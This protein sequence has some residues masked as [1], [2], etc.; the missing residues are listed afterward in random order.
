MARKKAPPEHA[1]HERW[2]VSYADFITLL[3]AFFVVM[4]ANSQSDAEKSERMAKA[5]EE[6]FGSPGGSALF[7]KIPESGIPGLGNV[8]ITAPGGKRR[9]NP[10]IDPIDH[11][12]NPGDH[13]PE[14]PPIGVDELY[15]EIDEILTKKIHEAMKKQGEIKEPPFEIEKTFLGIRINLGSSNYFQSGSATMKT[16]AIRTVNDLGREIRKLK[17]DSIRIRIE[18]HTDN[19]PLRGNNKYYDNEELSAVRAKSVLT[20]FLAIPNFPRDILS[21]TGYGDQRPIATNTT[22]EGRAQNRRVEILIERTG[23]ALPPETK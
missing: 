23:N 15:E 18:G 12:N 7:N 8:K 13:P 11:N 21:F 19:V 4:F 1:N 6:S 10:L 2:L 5:M 16:D 22:K 20:N 3:F 17:T 14:Q 9:P